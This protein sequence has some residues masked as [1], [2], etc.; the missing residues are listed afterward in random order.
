MISLSLS[1]RIWVPRI[2]IDSTRFPL[3]LDACLREAPPRGT[4]AG[5]RAGVRVHYHL[6]Y[7]PPLYP[8]R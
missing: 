8:V 7:P 6:F 1:N 2:D 5:E 3:S 4:K